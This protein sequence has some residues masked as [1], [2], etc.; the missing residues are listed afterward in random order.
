MNITPLT[1][2]TLRAWDFAGNYYS[3]HDIF[4]SIEAFVRDESNA[5]AE[6]AEALFIMGLTRA[7]TGMT[8]LPGVSATEDARIVQE[9]LK[10]IAGTAG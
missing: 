8:C 4:A 2:S 5:L 6:R 9:Y 1:I 10:G 3:D 7:D